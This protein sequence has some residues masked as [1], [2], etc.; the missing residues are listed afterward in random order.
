MKRAFRWAYKRSD[1]YRRGLISGEEAYIPRGSLYLM[2]LISEGAYIRKDLYPRGVYPRGLISE[3]L[4][5]GIKVLFE[6]RAA[7]IGRYRFFLS[8]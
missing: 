2:E 3:G 6:A 1:L 5:T 7:H 4:K 8:I